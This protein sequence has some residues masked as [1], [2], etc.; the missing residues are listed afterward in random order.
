[1]NFW[2]SH[3]SHTNTINTRRSDGWR[4]KVT[5]NPNIS[6]DARH[7][8]LAA[9]CD[10]IPFH[11][12]KNA[13]SGWPF[14]ITAENAPLGAYRKNQHQHMFALAP[15]DEIRH[16]DNGNTY[17][18]KRDPQSIQCVLL[19]LVDE[20][21]HGQ[22]TGFNIRDFSRPADDPAHN[23]MLKVILLFF[24]GDYPGQGKVANMLHSGFKACHWCHHYFETHSRGH[25]VA[26]GTRQHLPTDD[27]YRRDD[28]F[29]G[30]P[31]I[32]DPPA[33]RTSAEVCA[34]ADELAGFKGAELKRQQKACGV[35]GSCILRV[36]DMFDLI[37]D[38]TGDMMHLMKAMW[39]AR[40]LPMLKG[41]FVQAKPLKPEMTRADGDGG[42][43]A[44]TDAE[45]AD[46]KIAYDRAK[47]EWSKV[48][49]VHQHTPPNI[50]HV[51]HVLSLVRSCALVHRYHKCTATCKHYYHT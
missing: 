4:R 1:M 12:D 11:K 43:V 5:D 34:K 49:Q 7:Q 48:K 29:H 25:N 26:R 30:P 9:G 37:W 24:M 17:V 36:L 31:E 3:P 15:S 39:G 44:Y 33:T 27:A 38:I 13:S 42:Q 41:N 35:Y 6:A 14:V 50:A 47:L 16:D 46:R 23:F 10:G 22:D 51:I 19:L 28:S 40:M 32:R 45:K 18:H 21:L 2:W 8:A 20:L